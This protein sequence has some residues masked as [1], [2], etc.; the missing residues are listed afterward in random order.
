MRFVNKKTR[1]Y[2]CILLVLLLC[3]CLSDFL[4]EKTTSQRDVKVIVVESGETALTCGEVGADETS[5]AGHTISCCYW[6]VSGKKSQPD[7]CNLAYDNTNTALYWTNTERDS[8]QI[9]WF[10]SE[11]RYN[12]VRSGGIEAIE[13]E[14]DFETEEFIALASYCADCRLDICSAIIEDDRVNITAVHNFCP[15]EY[16]EV[17]PD[18]YPCDPY[19]QVA[20]HH[21]HYIRIPK[22]DYLPIDVTVYTVD[23]EDAQACEYPEEP[24]IH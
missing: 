12:F 6:R 7:Y 22:T 8:Y 1:A 21:I 14:V 2:A 19:D 15:I 13:C 3:G 11:P 17:W 18:C 4:Y 20:H 5:N 9:Q 24:P 16:P 23:N 10:D